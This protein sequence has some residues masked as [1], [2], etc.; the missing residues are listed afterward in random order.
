MIYYQKLLQKLKDFD[1]DR[2]TAFEKIEKS[3]LDDLYC[4]LSSAQNELQRVRPLL[5]GI[6]AIPDTMFTAALTNADKQL[7]AILMFFE[8]WFSQNLFVGDQ[9]AWQDP[10]L[11]V[12]LGANSTTR[13]LRARGAAEY[14]K[15]HPRATAVVSGGGFSSS[16]TEAQFMQRELQEAGLTN[17][18]YLEDKSMDTIGN[19]LF[20]KFLLKFNKLIFEGIKILIVTSRFH[21]MRSL[22]YFEQLFGK[23]AIFAAHG[24][25]TATSAS[26]EKLSVHELISQ[27][28]ASHS[29][30]IFEQNEVQDDQ[31]V[32]LKLFENHA[33]YKNRYDL[34]REFLGR[35]GT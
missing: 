12:V 10:D 27:Y 28:N 20:T 19:A 13:D 7:E 33:L 11:V 15:S 16:M 5:T 34:I 31:D 26:L 1:I 21:T 22:F 6:N 24:V 8:D 32:L 3:T 29:L 23:G 30:G 35:I 9:T 14:L 4:D 2:D 25:K 17:T 18:I